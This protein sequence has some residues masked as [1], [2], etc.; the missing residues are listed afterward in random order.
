T[1][2]PTV[3]AGGDQHSCL[4]SPNIALDGTVTTATGGRWTS[5]GTGTFSPNANTID[6][7]YIPSPADLLLPSV[8][9]TLTTTGNGQCAAYNNVMTLFFDPL[10]VVDPITA[11]KDVICS[12]NNVNLSTNVT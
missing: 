1:T 9:L 10:P 12:G 5:S 6:V 7:T 8:N 11:N 2:I 4:T 3:N